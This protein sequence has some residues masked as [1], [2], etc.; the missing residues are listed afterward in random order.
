M[1]SISQ[2]PKDTES[3]VGKTSKNIDKLLHLTDTYYTLFIASFTL[4]RQIS[5]NQL[6]LCTLHVE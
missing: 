5:M 2:G 6:G 4:K 3:S 1:H